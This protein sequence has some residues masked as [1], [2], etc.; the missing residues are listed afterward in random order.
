MT[1]DAR[2]FR[3]RTHVSRDFLQSAAL[4]RNA[5]LVVWEYVSNG[6]QYVD[7]RTPPVV[8]VRLEENRKNANFGPS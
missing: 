3:L 7:G 6:L 1:R 2:Q 8:R 5:H 4:F